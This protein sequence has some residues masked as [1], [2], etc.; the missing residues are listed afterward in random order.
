MTATAQPPAPVTD[1]TAA[2][3]LLGS[4]APDE[5][6][7]A[8]RAVSGVD[9]QR[10]STAVEDAISGIAPAA[11][12]YVESY[13]DLLDPMVELL[14]R[15]RPELGLSGEAA[16]LDL[17]WSATEAPFSGWVA[18][19]GLGEGVALRL[20]DRLRA[21]DA[22]ATRL[23]EPASALPR[24]K[25][26]AAQWLRFHSLV[27]AELRSLSGSTADVSRLRELFELSFTELGELFGASRQAATKW[28]RDGLPPSRRAKAAT[29]VAIGEL[30][31]RK[32]RPGRLPAVARR[33]AAAYGDRS[34]LDRIAA[35]EHEELLREVRES[36]DW[37]ATA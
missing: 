19:R 28:L 9:L 10:L 6:L 23:V 29:V 30:L 25:L 33:P 36:F 2:A 1:E 32:L 26:S 20:V 24:W 5:V 4:A 37:A 12:L 34:M 17:L 35:D 7:A 13:R 15:Q 14:A 8:L 21:F 27:E 18:E 16:V 3:W 22:A 31:E 11:A